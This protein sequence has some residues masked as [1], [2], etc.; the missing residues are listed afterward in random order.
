[1]ISEISAATTEQSVG[2][3]QVGDAVTQLDQVTKQNAALVE[4]CAAAAESLK[5]QAAKLSELVSVFKV[6]PNRATNVRRPDFKG[7]AAS[8]ARVGDVASPA[9][10]K[11]GTDNWEAF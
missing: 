8:G 10:N 4:E 11:T 2:I 3:N 7:T 1:M 6:G 9:A 5:Y